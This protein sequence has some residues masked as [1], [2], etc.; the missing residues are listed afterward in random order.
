MWGSEH[1]YKPISLESSAEQK[2]RRYPSSIQPFGLVWER[3]QGNINKDARQA[4]ADAFSL[5]KRG[6]R[7]QGTLASQ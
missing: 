6:L 2:R 5:L 1:A 7:L 4:I 3:G